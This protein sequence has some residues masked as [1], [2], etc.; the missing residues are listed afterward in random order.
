MSNKNPVITKNLFLK[1]IK[2]QTQ[3]WFTIN[4][5]SINELSLGDQFIM[6]QGLEVG[7]RARDIFPGGELISISDRQKAYELTKEKLNDKDIHTLYEATF[8]P[9][10]YVA[11]ADIIKRNKIG[12][13]LIEVKSGVN[14]KSEYID[15]IAYTTMI[16]QKCGYDIT[17]VSLILISKDYRLGMDDKG[18][19]KSIEHTNEVHQRAKEFD[20]ISEDIATIVCLKD[21]PK[22]ILIQECR[23]CEYFSTHCIGIG[24]QYPIF[25]I[26]RLSASKV[27]ELAE[28]NVVAI[29]DMPKDFKLTENQNKIYQLILSGTPITESGIKDVLAEIQWPACYLDFETISTAIPLYEDIAPYTQIPVQFSAHICSK[30]GEILEHHQ[31]IADPTAD[32]R[33][34][35]IKKLL[36]VLNKCKSIIVYSSFEKGRINELAKGFPEYADNLYECIDRLFDLEPIF[37]K[38]YIHPEFHGKTSIKKV[39]PVLIPEMSY[40]HLGINDGLSATASLVKLARNEFNPE[41]AENITKQLT[42]YCKLDT[43]AMVRVHEQ[44]AN[45]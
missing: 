33:L 12:W 18:L 27:S 42:D 30:P 32:P 14:D 38:Y 41:E 40:D 34:G 8:C 31:Y 5:G 20:K 43:L 15:D 23:N 11:K 13:H 21:R 7:R 17:E 39:M 26:P 9:D 3:C 4:V 25:D 37:K 36:K 24:V 44:L 6:E 45:L 35:I 28:I 16:I 19:F 2:C 29:E 10:G 22:E 1:A